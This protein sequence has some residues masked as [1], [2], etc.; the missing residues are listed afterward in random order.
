MARERE[1]VDG[2]ANLVAEFTLDGLELKTGDIICTANGKE[3]IPVGEFWRLLGRLL[4]GEVDHVIIYLGPDGLC[5]EAGA[6]G[7]NLFML[8]GA[9]WDATAMVE[10][11]G[12]Y[13]DTL[14][15]AAY[16]LKGRGLS[17]EQEKNIRI[18]VRRF[19]LK[20]ARLKKPY[21]L[22]FLNPNTDRAFYCSQLPFRAY[23]PH[24]I[25]LNTGAGV[26]D[27]INSD[28]IIYPQ[29]IWAGCFHR[30]VP[31]RQV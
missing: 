31:V 2:T 23:L 9:T 20:Q 15:G 29:E 28:R 10:Q 5:V 21:N 26:T 27:L 11:R 25:N 19:C 30:K 13:V 22:N 24:G 14:V 17:P 8:P 1:H 6:K 7:V 4:P 16:P 12:P 18:Q 3:D